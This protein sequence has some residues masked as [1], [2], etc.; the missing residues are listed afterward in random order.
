MFSRFFRIYDI[1]HIYYYGND[2]CSSIGAWVIGNYIYC[3]NLFMVCGWGSSKLHDAMEGNIC[4]NV[5]YHYRNHNHFQ[6]PDRLDCMY[7]VPVSGADRL[8]R[9]IQ[10]LQQYGIFQHNRMFCFLLH[11][12]GNEHHL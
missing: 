3:C 6:K 2:M 11:L 9:R 4:R 8:Q 7:V 1:H 5:E 12:C 10:C